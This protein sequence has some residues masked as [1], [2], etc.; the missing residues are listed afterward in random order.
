MLREIIITLK[1]V[2]ELKFWILELGGG[3]HTWYL[4][5]E[6]FDVYAFDG[7]ISA[8]NKLKKRLDYDGLHADIR[9]L[10]GIDLDYKDG[11]FDSVI[12]N[13]SIYCS[14]VENIKRM[15][16]EVY[17][18][19]KYDGMLFT[20]AFLSDTTGYGM[21]EEIEKNT[22]KNITEGNLAGRGIAHF[23]NKDELESILTDVGFSVLNTNYLEYDDLGNKV[24][25]VMVQAKK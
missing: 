12:D 6:A 22:Y 11:F 19:L 5:R 8:I 3:A 17:R 16:A 4:A 20:V 24:S 15:Y 9:V 25:M 23:Y 10:D 2:P 18:V 7:S 21:G 13:V 1:I 14:I